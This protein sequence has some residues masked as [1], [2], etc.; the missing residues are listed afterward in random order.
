MGPGLAGTTTSGGA[1]TNELMGK[2]AS[3]KGKEKKLKRIQENER[4]RKGKEI[5]R[6]ANALRGKLL[7]G[8][9]G[10]DATTHC[11]WEN[12]NVH[13][14]T[15]DACALGEEWLEWTFQLCKKNMK[16]LYET[17][18]GWEDEKKREELKHEDA[19]FLLACTD[20]G[21][22]PIG[23]AHIRFEMEDTRHVLY[24]YELQVVP[25]E[26]GKGIGKMLMAM[27]E[28]IARKLEMAWILLTVLK[29]NTGAVNFY[30]KLG[31]RLDETSP[32]AVDP[33]GEHG[34][35]I[36]SKPCE[37]FGDVKEVADA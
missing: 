8:K 32:G 25:D 35:E 4:R 22:E 34:Y 7:E 14:K 27:V 37:S 29:E 26:Q 30:Y 13:W 36:L 28:I 10:E 24:V 1:N 20:Q 9:E 11:P 31:Y 5:V 17:A 3:S 23:Y 15:Y 21:N 6:R 12:G 16:R 33:T 18:W 19:R 2:K